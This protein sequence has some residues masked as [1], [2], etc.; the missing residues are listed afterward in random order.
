VFMEIESPGFTLWYTEACPVIRVP[1]D[2]SLTTVPLG[3]TA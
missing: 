3:T 1:Y 2:E